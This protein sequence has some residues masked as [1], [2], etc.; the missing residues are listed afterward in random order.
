MMTVY[1]IP[2]LGCTDKL[3]INT[4]LKNCNIVVLN[5]PTPN[6]NDTMQGYAQK[7]ISQINQNKPY[8]LLGVSFGGML[9]TELAHIIKPHKTFIVS[10]AKH[11]YELPWFLR[12]LGKIKLHKLLS[13]RYHRKMAYHGK[14]F[15]GF[16]T[17]YIPEFL[18]MVNSMTANYF[19]YCINTIVTWKRA[20]ITAKIIHLHG[21]SDRLLQF[22]NTTP[23]Y[24]IVNGGHAMIVFNASDI[25]NI[26][27]K[28]LILN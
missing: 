9:C 3:F 25:N 12:L 5:W 22:K 10:S 21:T 14:W 1:C 24:S 2:G 8:C 23:N 11:K 17:A 26:I 13:E 27:E 28:E 7:F 20:S 15:I 6:K 19:T 4:Q 18:G 16:G